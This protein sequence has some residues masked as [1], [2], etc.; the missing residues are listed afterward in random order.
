M[1]T[2]Q[3]L[4][5]LMTG[6]LG[7][8][9]GQVVNQ[10]TALKIAAF[11]SCIRVIA[12]TIGSLP[13]K[14]FEVVD[15][16][17]R[18]APGHPLF[19][20]LRRRPNGWQTS[21]EW[22]EMMT[23]HCAM[24]GNAYSFILWGEN[25]RTGAKYIRELIPLNPDRMTV[26]QNADFSVVYQYSKADGTV[27]N[28]N[29]DQIFHLRGMTLDGFDGVS[30]I[31]YARETLG[32]SL[33]MQEY[34]AKLFANNAQPGLVLSKDGRLSDDAQRRLK[35]QFDGSRNAHKT[36]ILE[37]GLKAERISFSAE[38]TQFIE[39]V[40]L[41]RSEIAGLFRVPPHMIGDLDRATFSNIEEQNIAFVTHCIRPWATR[42]EQALGKS[43]FINEDRFYPEINL[44]GLLR[45]N[46][47]SRYQAYAI[48]RNWG[49]LSA[50]DIRRKE[51]ENSIGEQGD[52]YLQPVNMTAADLA[53][54][55]QTNGG[56]NDG[57]QK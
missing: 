30:M 22:R 27:G 42:W 51:N 44:E 11:Q 52:V 23:A 2:Q 32:K 47:L 55:M 16:G 34:S 45:G 9:S 12:E 54:S 36:L 24:R 14:V 25:F 35:E 18:P 6:S 8:A 26:K 39:T 37:E 28:F 53:R 31:K 10:E 17:S 21:M 41:T 48:G 50:N 20:L 49:W 57:N 19:T 5:W 1:L 38:D 29:Q 40:K 4:E 7:T 33:G 46:I 43:L 13:L 15:A 56:N 3:D